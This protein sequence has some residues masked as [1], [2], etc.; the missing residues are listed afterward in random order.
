M[1]DDKRRKAV[2]V[3]AF[4]EDAAYQVLRINQGRD[5]S[6]YLESPFK[7]GQ[8]HFSYHARWKQELVGSS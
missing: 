5:G 8:A 4:T 6:I 1:V 3:V 2:T 7:E